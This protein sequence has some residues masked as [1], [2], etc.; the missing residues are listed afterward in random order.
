MTTDPSEARR[1][2]I[3]ELARGEGRVRVTELATVLDV[4]AETVRR[5]LRSLEDLGLVRRTH[6]G[7]LPVDR[8][9]FETRMAQRAVQSAPEKQRIAAAAVGLLEGCES[10][11]VDEGSTALAAAHQLL[12]IDRPLTVVTHSVP[13][14]VALSSRPR[15]IGSS[16]TSMLSGSWVRGCRRTAGA[17]LTRGHPRGEAA[18][19]RAPAARSFQATSANQVGRSSP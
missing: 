14:V 11:F 2:Q 5:D 16:A 7:A 1:R 10:L 3:L 15:T 8:S 18:A 6:G 17:R 19:A 9:G 4:A 12:E 13:V